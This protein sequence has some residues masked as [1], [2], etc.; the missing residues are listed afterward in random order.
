[1]TLGLQAQSLTID[2][3]DPQQE[4]EGAGVS[5]SLYLGHHFSMNAE[6]QDKAIRLINQDLNMQYLQDYPDERYPSDDPDYFQR[7]CELF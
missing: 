6:N 5:I 2:L 4:Y 3:D 7:R 1:M